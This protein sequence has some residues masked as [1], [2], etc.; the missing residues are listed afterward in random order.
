M[1]APSLS[2][3][4]LADVPDPRWAQGRLYNLRHGLLF[5]ILAIVTG[6]NSYRGDE[7][8]RLP[9]TITVHR[10]GP[11]AAFSLTWKR[12]PAHSALGQD[13]NHA[14]LAGVENLLRLFAAS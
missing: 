5:S 3:D 11:N 6:C 7:R 4:G 10:R 13:R 8:T 1:A 9:D 2:L 14:G 12:A